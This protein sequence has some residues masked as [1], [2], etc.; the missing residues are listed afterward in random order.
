MFFLLFLLAKEDTHSETIMLKATSLSYIYVYRYIYRSFFLSF[1]LSFLSVCFCLFVFSGGELASEGNSKGEEGKKNQIAKERT[2]MCSKP[3][4]VL[5]ERESMCI[6]GEIHI[7]HCILK[8]LSKRREGREREDSTKRER[9]ERESRKQTNTQSA[10]H[11]RLIR[12]VS[13]FFV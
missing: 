2:S 10:C 9:E 8:A 7:R 11:T 1:F 3:S 12:P 4:Y 5:S 6:H 13:R